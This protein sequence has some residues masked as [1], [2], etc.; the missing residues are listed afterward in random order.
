MD[1]QLLAPALLEA[2]SDVK[3]LYST[4]FKKDQRDWFTVWQQLGRPGVRQ[5]RQIAHL[6]TEW[7]NAVKD[8]DAPGALRAVTA[9][10]KLGCDD[11]LDVF[12]TGQQVEQPGTGYIYILSTREQPR[13]LKIGYTNRS[14]EKRVKEI[15]QATGVVIPYGVRALWSVPDARAVEA[16]VHARLAPYRVRRDR[17]FFDLHFRDAVK[18]IDDYLNN[19]TDQR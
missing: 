2:L 3:G 5:C 10:R 8:D 6:L 7:R 13:M 15:N 14:V 12:L 17:E 16:E 1:G 9:L 18:I 19:C 4:S 11:H